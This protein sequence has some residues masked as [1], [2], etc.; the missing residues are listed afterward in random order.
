MGPS[1]TKEY[2]SFAVVQESEIGGQCLSLKGA[3]TGGSH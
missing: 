3:A 2:S 1:G